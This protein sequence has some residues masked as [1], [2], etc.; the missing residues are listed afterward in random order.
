[1]T[2]LPDQP[3]EN[4]KELIRKAREGD[5]NA[6]GELLQNFRD[7]LLKISIEELGNGLNGKVGASDVVQEATMTAIKNFKQFKDHDSPALRAWLRTILLNQ[8]KQHIRTFKGTQKRQLDRECSLQLNSSTEIPVVDPH[9]T[10]Q[11]NALSLEKSAGL[12]RAMRELPDEYQQ[13]IRLRSFE[14]LDFATIGEAMSRSAD[15]AKKLWTRAIL[16]LQQVMAREE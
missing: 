5:E 2:N 4:F 13:V 16:K 1:M 8:V 11:S 3:N 10:P 12:I 9:L 7:Y 15:A 14:V 6:L